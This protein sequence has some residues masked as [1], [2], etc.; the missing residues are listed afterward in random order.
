MASTPDYRK[1]SIRASHRNFANVKMECGITATPPVVDTVSSSHADSA[2]ATE[3]VKN[4]VLDR[5]REEVEEVDVAGQQEVR[6]EGVEMLGAA[7]EV[8]GMEKEV[9]EVLQP[10]SP[11]S[12]LLK[13]VPRFSCFFIQRD[14]SQMLIVPPFPQIRQETARRFSRCGTSYALATEAPRRSPRRRCRSRCNALGRA[15]LGARRD[16]RFS[17]YNFETGVGRARSHH[18]WRSSGVGTI[19]LDEYA[20]AEWSSCDRR[21]RAREVDLANEKGSIGVQNGAEG[22]R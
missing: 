4:T 9:R 11:I 20:V 22:G 6:M 1:I 19:S 17:H 21:W 5:V 12:D 14:D 18:R 10:G 16:Y 2:A 13:Y 7:K 3:R 8:N 15:P